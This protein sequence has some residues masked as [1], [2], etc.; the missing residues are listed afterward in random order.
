MEIIIQALV[1]IALSGIIGGL[2]TIWIK[3]KEL[4][5]WH[6]VK[7]TEGVRVWYTR[8]KNME[9]MLSK[10]VAMI[11]RMDRREERQILIQNHQIETIEKHT[12]A[13]GQLC[14]VVEALTKVVLK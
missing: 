5:M 3:V 9:D 7:D 8:N 14:A 12:Q 11:E 6:D 1:G 10:M 4:H 13:I 2:F